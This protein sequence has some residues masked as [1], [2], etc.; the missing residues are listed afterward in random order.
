MRRTSWR[1]TA[2]LSKKM[3]WKHSE[4]GV[5]LTWTVKAID[6]KILAFD[7][8]GIICIIGASLCIALYSYFFNDAF[9][10]DIFCATAAFMGFFLVLH[11]LPGKS[12]LIF[13][14]KNSLSR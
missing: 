12:F 14:K 7:G 9:E 8:I 1:K 6:K 13:M 11:G 2:E 10:V 4:E 3:E 5:L